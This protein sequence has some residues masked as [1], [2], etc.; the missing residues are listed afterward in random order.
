LYDK[1]TNQHLLFNLPNCVKVGFVLAERVLY[2]PS[3]GF[4][5]LLA[6]GLARLP[7]GLRFALLSSIVLL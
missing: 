4:C 3:I 7:S 6:L 2:L 1:Q 5:V